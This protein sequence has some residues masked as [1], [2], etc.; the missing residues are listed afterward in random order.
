[1]CF[2]PAHGLD[3]VDM[4]IRDLV[5]AYEEKDDEGDESEGMAPLYGGY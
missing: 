4:L 5:A 3:V 1:M 2:T